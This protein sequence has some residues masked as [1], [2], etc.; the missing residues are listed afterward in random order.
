MTEDERLREL[1]LEQIKTVPTKSIETTYL[2]MNELK[3]IDNLLD[4]HY[5]NYENVDAINL[6]RKIRKILEGE[7]K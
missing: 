2:N 1:R 3:V 5:I 4:S 7:M 6:I